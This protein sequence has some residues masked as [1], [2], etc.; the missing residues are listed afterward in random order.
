VKLIEI[1]SNLEGFE[2]DKGNITKNWER[3]GVT[4]SECEEVFFNEPIIVKEA[5]AYS[6]PEHRQFILGKTDN[7]RLLFIVF[8]IRGKKIRVISARDMSVKE[9]RV[10]NEAV[11]K[12]S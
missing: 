11:K 1:F 12:D 6:T 5:T 4:Y 8:T 7:E 2:W 3:H 10:F 9:R